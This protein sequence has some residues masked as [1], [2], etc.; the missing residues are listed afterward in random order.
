MSP[1]TDSKVVTSY[2]R[3]ASCAGNQVRS[4]A[5]ES[6]GNSVT[7]YHECPNHSVMTHPPKMD[8]D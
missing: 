2:E 8:W 7:H 3:I 4:R 1:C 5:S 6:Q